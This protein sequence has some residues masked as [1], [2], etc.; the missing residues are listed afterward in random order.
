MTACGHDIMSASVAC[1]KRVT[2]VDRDSCE[3][4]SSAESANHDIMSASE[5]EQAQLVQSERRMSIVIA[6]KQRQALKARI[7]I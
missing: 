3:A 6:A 2:N 1:S 5:L 7:T 4:A